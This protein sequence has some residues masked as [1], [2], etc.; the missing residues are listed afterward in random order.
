MPT[1]NNTAVAL[2]W[3]WEQCVAWYQGENDDY[4]EWKATWIQNAN[5]LREA[6]QEEYEYRQEL[7]QNPEPDMAAP[8]PF[9]MRL[10]AN[11]IDWEYVYRETCD[12]MLRYHEAYGHLPPEYA[13]PPADDEPVGPVMIEDED[14]DDPE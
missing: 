12:D 13:V 1:N 6:A 11:D 8:S 7:I 2:E 14:S 4:N 10:L 5:D 9:D 3:A